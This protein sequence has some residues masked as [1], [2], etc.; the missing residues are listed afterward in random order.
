MRL[1]SENLVIPV[2]A[3]DSEN[4]EVLVGKKQRGPFA[5]KMVF[6][7]GKAEGSGLQR[8]EAA[9]ELNEETGIQVDPETLQYVGKLLIQDRRLVSKRFGNVF[10]YMVNL[11]KSVEVQSTPELGELH[12]VNVNDPLLPYEMPT[13]VASWWPSVRDFDGEPTITHI[14]YADDGELEIIT[15]KPDFQNEP[16]EIIAHQIYSVQSDF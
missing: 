1:L 14:N 7:G 2:R 11:D 15:K 9:R 16:G 4:R 12:W 10:I 3:I 5:G 13:D 8:E 6:P